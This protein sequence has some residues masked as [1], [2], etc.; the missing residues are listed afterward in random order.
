MWGRKR[1]RKPEH[2]TTF[3]DDG[4]TIEGCCRFTG[5]TVVAGRITGEQIAADHLIV[6][7]TGTVTGVIRATVVTVAGTICGTIVASERVELLATARITGDI[8]TPALTID[9]GAIVDG[10]CHT[11]RAFPAE[12]PIALA[13][14]TG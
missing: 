13:P 4:S 10:R 7:E 12:S 5:S 1:V 11:M 8:E 14:Q 2:C 9:A 3:I 6:G